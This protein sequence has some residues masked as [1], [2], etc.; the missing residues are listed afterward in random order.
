MS[1]FKRSLEA[2]KIIKAKTCKEVES[3]KF[4]KRELVNFCLDLRNFKTIANKK[5][6]I[7]SVSA[8]SIM[9]MVFNKKDKV[10]KHSVY[11][12]PVCLFEEYVTLPEKIRLLG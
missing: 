12:W 7:E 10:Y 9:I 8:S 3:N 1:Q 4:L 6:R 2:G 5:I 11:N